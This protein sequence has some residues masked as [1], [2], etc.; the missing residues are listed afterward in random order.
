M[1]TADIHIRISKEKMNKINNLSIK[2]RRSKTQVIEIAL[3]NYF[4]LRKI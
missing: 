2:D 4:T 1:K 3:D